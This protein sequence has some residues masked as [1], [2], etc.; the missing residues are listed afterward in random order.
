MWHLIEKV[1]KCVQC[2]YREGQ[3]LSCTCHP[4][5]RVSIVESTAGTRFLYILILKRVY[6][7]SSLCGSVVNEPN[8]DP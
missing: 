7:G 6:P 8:R 5:T 3:F 2:K 4:A 1:Q